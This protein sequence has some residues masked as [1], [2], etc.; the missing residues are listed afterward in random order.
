MSE[1]TFII[2]GQIFKRSRS[3][4]ANLF[5]DRYNINLISSIPAENPGRQ[6]I[7]KRKKGAKFHK[8]KRVLK[9][10]EERFKRTE[11]EREKGAQNH[12]HE[13]IAK[14]VLIHTLSD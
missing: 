10:N 11:R 5:V 14:S 8:E 1:W 9:L 3:R 7:R 13:W 6:Q 2:S 12:F 4:S